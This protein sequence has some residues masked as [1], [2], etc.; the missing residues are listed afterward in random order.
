VKQSSPKLTLNITGD[1]GEIEK[2]GECIEISPTIQK[3]QKLFDNNTTMMSS[4]Y[5]NS[6]NYGVPNQLDNSLFDTKPIDT[7]YTSKANFS[8]KLFQHNA[9]K[10]FEIRKMKST[11]EKSQTIAQEDASS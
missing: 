8:N 5:V 3:Q 4:N 2:F 6:F 10:E 11:C 9:E 1:M 7:C